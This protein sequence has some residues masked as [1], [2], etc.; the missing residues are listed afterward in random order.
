M[1]S[2]ALSA[3][4]AAEQEI[5]RLIAEFEATNEALRRRKRQ[6]DEIGDE[7]EEGAVRRGPVVILPGSSNPGWNQVGAIEG[8]G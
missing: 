3:L 4:L 1:P 8:G 2:S 7:W 5:L 6:D